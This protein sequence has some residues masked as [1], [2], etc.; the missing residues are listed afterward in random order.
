MNRLLSKLKKENKNIIG[1]D[2][3]TRYIKIME[4]SG[5]SLDDIVLEKYAKILIDPSYL[6]EHGEFNQEK[7][8]DISNLL[9]ESWIKNDFSTRNITFCLKSN[10]VIIKKTIIPELNDESSLKIAVE[11]EISKYIPND[12]TLENLMLDYFNIGKNDIDPN[13]NDYLIVAA[14]KE[15]IE[16]LQAILE[17]AELIPE[18]LDIELFAMQNLLK[19]MSPDN[20]NNGT[21]VIADCADKLL[22]MFVF[23]NG[24]L[25]TTKDVQIGGINLNYDLV[26]NLDISFEDSEILK[27]SRIGNDTYEVFEKSFLNNYVTEFL[28]CLAYFNSANS[29]VEIDEIILIGG[30]ASMPY[31]DKAIVDGLIDTPEIIVK[32]EPYIARPLEKV[33]KS[34]NIDLV[35]FSQ[36]EASLFLVTSLA[37]R[38]YLRQF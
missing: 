16:D 7:I 17:G 35:Q 20:F 19:L 32:T 29:I 34:N 3:G 22:R 28:S 33:S 25:V 24:N 21:F 14:K 36:D 27:L 15:K 13:K 10:N 18:I 30:V 8:S 37:L 11:E 31:F 38:K 9:K 2:F 12:L 6:N 26:N 5:S 23:I 1:L 4:L